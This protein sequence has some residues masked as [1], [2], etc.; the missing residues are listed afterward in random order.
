M[1]FAVQDGAGRCKTLSDIE[2]RRRL[3]SIRHRFADK[4]PNPEAAI[5]GLSLVTEVI[6]RQLG[7]ELYLE[8]IEGSLGLLNGNVIEMATG[9]G[10]TLTAVGPAA[11]KALAKR[12]TMS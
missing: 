4:H 5:S 12:G 10:K 8:Q 9:E 2:I 7:V 6:R 1:A 11:L 3:N